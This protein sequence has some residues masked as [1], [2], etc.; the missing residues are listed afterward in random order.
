MRVPV[1]VDHELADVMSVSFCG[2]PPSVG[3]TL[4]PN[5]RPVLNGAVCTVAIFKSGLVDVILSRPAHG[6]RALGLALDL[7]N[8]FVRFL[9]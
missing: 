3:I 1:W 5:L 2:K 4:G 7:G 6:A 8:T 9:G